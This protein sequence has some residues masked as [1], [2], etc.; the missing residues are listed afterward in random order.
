MTTLTSRNGE[1]SFGPGLPTVLL[2]DQLRIMDQSDDVLNELQQG[3]YDKLVE[4]AQWGEEVGTQMV[5][6]LITHMGIDEVDLL[7]KI[8]KAVHDEIGCPIAL[9]SRNPAALEPALA[10]LQPYKVVINSITAE[11]ESIES[12]MP[13]VKKYNAAFFGMPLS[14]EKGLPM[15]VEDRLFGVEKIL[16]AAEEYGIAR[17]DIAIDSICMASAAEPNSMMVTL[18]T[19]RA[20]SEMGIATVLGIGNAGFG[21]PD[22]TVI[23]LAYLISAIPWGLDLAFVDPSTRGLVETVRATD[24]LVGNDPSGSVYIKDYR[25]RK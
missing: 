12:L 8:A 21:M 20:I 4:L 9:D 11:D 14:D 13:L 6:I 17:D 22:Q 23:D 19:N 3:R 1:L 10:A 5:D 18:E 16:A 24:F 25:N 7:P 2:N 15:T